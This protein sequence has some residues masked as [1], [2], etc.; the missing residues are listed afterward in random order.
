MG[1]GPEAEARL[2]LFAK[3]KFGEYQLADPDGVMIDISEH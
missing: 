2:A 3:C 1:A